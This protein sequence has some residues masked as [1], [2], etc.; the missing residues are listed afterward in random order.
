MARIHDIPLP[1]IVGGKA[2]ERE[3]DGITDDLLSGGAG[4]EGLRR[5]EPPF[6]PNPDRPR[7]EDIRKRTLRQNYRALADLSAPW[8]GRDYGPGAA[9]G[10]PERIAGLE[11]L[12]LMEGRVTVMLQVP[13]HFDSRRPFLIAAPSSGSRGVYGAV[14]VVGEWALQRGFAVV[15]TDKGTGVGYHHLD[16]NRVCLIDG[17]WD[18]ADRA[19]AGST[20]TAATREQI[21]RHS[22]NRPF[23]LAVK[24][25]HAG[26]NAQKDWGRMVL[27]AIDVAR[28][29]LDRMYP[30][31]RPRL[32]VIAAG[33]SN[34][35]L[36]SIMA[37]EQDRENRID[38]LAV[39]EPN[40]TPMYRNDLAI[41]CG[42]APPLT[43]HSR[44]LIDYVT[45]FNL[46]QPC[47]SLAPEAALAPL[48][49]G[50]FG[51]TRNRCEN[52]CL[53]LADK[54]LLAPGS[55]ESMA[56]QASRILSSS[57]ILPDQALFMPSHDALNVY[58]S[59]AV[60][61]VSQYACASVLD[62][63]SGY[64]FSAVDGRGRPRPL[65]EKEEALLFSDQSGIPP[66]GPVALINDRDPDGPREDRQSLSPSTGR[67]D[68]NLDGA[69][70]LRRLVIGIDE[71]GRALFGE[72]ERLHR[73]VRRGMEAVRVSGN[74]RGCPA[75]IVT[76]RSDAV[77][78]VN[79]A[80][81][82]YVGANRLAEKSRS[83]LRYYE[84]TQAQHVDA[85]NMMYAD[86][87]RCDHPMRLT[88]LLVYYRRA[89]DRMV[90][91]LET[92]RPLPP[93]QV[94]RPDA[95]RDDLPDIADSPAPENRIR[96]ESNALFIPD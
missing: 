23:R 52:R 65:S 42:S 51:L 93:D 39:S 36:A 26:L 90:D 55:M 87:E 38:A 12:A 10:S 62:H 17:L 27:Q 46:F 66:L 34:G 56:R 15:Y 54:G 79:H 6:L 30:G 71:Q 88:P 5:P 35:G 89:L 16:P 57:G 32:R 14:G 40:V 1:F 49:P 21:S 31:I 50:H 63:L 11:F 85:L 70:S 84:V 13:R 64:S 83:L 67:E 58:R 2:V 19:G 95:N 33:I 96:F 25:A 59:I 47:A 68:L 45:L 80:S 72:E 75:V 37:R 3:Y 18:D 28:F 9:Y 81:R 86:T 41:M 61:Y 43:D 20:F 77:I 7:S 4:R 60:T 53:S 78:P 44:H 82:P 69:L 29:L 73:R 91:H 76:G 22:R 48:G 24:H 74:L 8:Y 92:G 94:I